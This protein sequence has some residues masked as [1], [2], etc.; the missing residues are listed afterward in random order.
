MT[1]TNKPIEK[2]EARD[3]NN[4]FPGKGSQI[5][6]KHMKICTIVHIIRRMQIKLHGD[7]T[8]DYQI[9]KDQKV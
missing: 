7:S 8:F 4:H 9:G 1:K 2:Q 6:P 3:M 5:V